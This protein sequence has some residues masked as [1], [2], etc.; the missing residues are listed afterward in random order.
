MFV[1]PDNGDL[2]KTTEAKYKQHIIRIFLRQAY[3][4]MYC[5]R[6]LCNC[7]VAYNKILPLLLEVTLTLD[8]N[9]SSNA[10]TIM[11]LF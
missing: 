5:T 4:I 9:S 3:G 7:N 11:Y 10:K 1:H 6:K 8:C 2:P